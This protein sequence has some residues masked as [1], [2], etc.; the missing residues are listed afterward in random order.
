MDTTPIP[1][2][3]EP[4]DH[5]LVHD[6]NSEQAQSL[7][8]LERGCKRVSEMTGSPIALISAVVLQALWI[9]VGS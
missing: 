2:T 1:L 3:P 7:S 9:V 5:P 6:V 4:T 8:P